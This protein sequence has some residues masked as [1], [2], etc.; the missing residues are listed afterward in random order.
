MS[1]NKSKVNVER[2]PLTALLTLGSNKCQCALCGAFFSGVSPFDRHLIG[3][4]LG[5]SPCRTPDQMLLLG[6]TQNVNGVWS[7]GS[8]AQAENAVT[9]QRIP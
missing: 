1:E 2:G 7:Y 8:A 3:I 5:L 6:M 9:T 4:G